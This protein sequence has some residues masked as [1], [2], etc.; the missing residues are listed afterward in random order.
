MYQVTTCTARLHAYPASISLA[1]AT[2][3]D[4]LNDFA[5]NMPPCLAE[6]CERTGGLHTGQ[7]VEF[8]VSERIDIIIV[9]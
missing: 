2:T 4:E 7:N 3:K 1:A 6:Y 8:E 9:P 5:G